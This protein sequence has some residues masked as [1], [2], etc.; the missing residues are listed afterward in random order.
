MG[1]ME[2]LSSED[3]KEYT[4]LSLTATISLGLKGIFKVKENF[5]G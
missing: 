1:A 2:G 5:L 3:V 4:Q